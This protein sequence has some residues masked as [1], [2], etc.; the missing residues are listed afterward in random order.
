MAVTYPSNMELKDLNEEMLWE[1][2]ERHRHEIVQKIHSSRLTSYLRQAKVLSEL[3]EEEILHSLKLTNR[4]MKAGYMLDLLRMRGKNGALAFLESLKLHKPDLYTLITGKEPT[5]Q[6]AN[7]SNFIET[8]QLTE[9]LIRAITGMQMELT[10]ERSIR[11][12][13]QTHYRHLQEKFQ[14]LER[15][16]TEL[17]NMEEEYNKQRKYFS[18]L[19][20]DLQKVKDESYQLSMRYTS[21]LQEK[22]L[23]ATRCRELQEELYNL[24][25]ELK[26]TKSDLQS[27]KSVKAKVYEEEIVKLKEEVETLTR[28]IIS[29]ETLDP[30]KKDILEHD[31]GE[32]LEGRQELISRMSS[33]REKAEIAESLRDTYLEEKESLLME[34]QRL[35]ME[36]HLYMEKINALQAQLTELKKERDQAYAARDEAQLQISQSLAEKDLLRQQ[37]FE[38]S[39]WN[40]KLRTE[41][42]KLK[43]E[44]T[45]DYSLKRNESFEMVSSFKSC[46][47]EPPSKDSLYQ[48]KVDTFQEIMSLGDYDQDSLRSLDADTEGFDSD[49]ELLQSP[50]SDASE[51]SIPTGEEKE[52]EISVLKPDVNNSNLE[53]PPQPITTSVPFFRL[54][55]RDAQRSPNRVTTV[56]FQGDSL[57]EQVEIIGGNTTGIFIHRVRPGSPANE[58]CLSAGTQ[59]L[60]VD[61]NMIEHHCRAFLEDSTLEEAIWSLKQVEG[62]CCLS[63]RINMGGYQTLVS[64]LEK[65]LVTSGDSFYIRANLKLEEDSRL[66]MP[67]IQCNDILHVTD[68][69]FKGKEEWKASRVDPY[70]KA[71]LDYRTIPN[72]YHAQELLIATIQGM[73][74]QTPPS[75][76]MLC[77]P[78]S[79]QRKVVRIVSTD[80][81]RTNPLWSSFDGGTVDTEKSKESSVKSCFTLM[82]Y[83]LVKPY[84]PAFLRP[85]IITPS[86]IST[87]VIA[88][89]SNQNF[90]KCEPE[91]LTGTEFVERTKN[92]DILGEKPGKDFHLCITQQAVQAVAEKKL[93][94]LLELEMDH[95]WRLHRAEMYPIILHV[96]ISDKN[97]K[98][99]KKAL[100]KVGASDNLL[101]DCSRREQVLLDRLPCL[102]RN[103]AP[104]SWRDV[105]S[106]VGC[107]KAAVTD[108]QQKIVWM[109]QD[110]R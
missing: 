49:L 95:L 64:H 28:K 79:E 12:C 69:V 42:M 24:K 98:R 108:E 4:V 63:V 74:Q 68:T 91:C 3:D 37:M 20:H 6:L 58:V 16:N 51:L 85:V 21:T 1:M 81:S 26:L 33:L 18:S 100:N 99:L 11:G 90:M 8:S 7:V 35:K 93:H 65:K 83:T 60:E 2:I 13:L 14:D 59:I 56:A 46:T 96:V 5:V 92:G 97:A 72:Y 39:D 71:D 84:K 10:E 47:A 86:L 50:K 36:S 19:Y 78:S 41:L 45:K 107:I 22:D 38:Q 25:F 82:P 57:L 73:T 54:P 109:E 87:I 103:I 17:K 101:L 110:P 52:G 32:A 55:R 62:F 43:A 34:C 77:K 27:C 104:E 70:N 31:L 44:K 106:L 15:K 102:H 61:Y 67:S 75:K 48:R 76:K 30:V 94:C 29:V 66:G 40:F 105:D 80:K 88:K 23:A 89:L 53:D 9:Y